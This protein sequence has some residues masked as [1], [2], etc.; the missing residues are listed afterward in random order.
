MVSCLN[1]LFIIVS[2]VQCCRSIHQIWRVK[3]KY[4]AWSSYIHTIEQALATNTHVYILCLPPKKEEETIG[5]IIFSAIFHTDI[6]YYKHLIYTHDY[7]WEW[8][9]NRC[10]FLN[11]FQAIFLFHSLIDTCL[12]SQSKTRQYGETTVF[13]LG[14]DRNS[15]ASL[16]G[17]SNDWRENLPLNRPP[18]GPVTTKMHGLTTTRTGT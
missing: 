8:L 3:S 17:P 4:I 10:L 9:M 6:T 13:F 11:L 18:S 15:C 16:F 2:M 12:S 1:L 5:N 7:V 14:S